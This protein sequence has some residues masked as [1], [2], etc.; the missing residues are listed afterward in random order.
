MTSAVDRQGVRGPTVEQ[1]IRHAR[2]L[3][4]DTVKAG[5]RK[6]AMSIIYL[7]SIHKSG[8]VN[9]DADADFVCGHV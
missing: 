5:A 3:R 6:T 1:H 9:V 2:Q 8:G 4:A 7:F